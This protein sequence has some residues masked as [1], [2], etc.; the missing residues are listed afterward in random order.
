MWSFECSIFNEVSKNRKDELSCCGWWEL[1]E[2][3]GF[4]FIF[5]DEF[6]EVCCKGSQTGVSFGATLSETDR[7]T[8][9][10]LSSPQQQKVSVQ[11]EPR[12]EWVSDN[13]M[14]RKTR[15]QTASVTSGVSDDSSRCAWKRD[16]AEKKR[17]TLPRQTAG[18][19]TAACWTVLI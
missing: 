12:G 17:G 13:N 19:Q 16:A 9:R 8:D 5:L 14:W 4:H 18:R 6:N 1:L 2:F 3:V 15:S 7:Q 11:L 10:S